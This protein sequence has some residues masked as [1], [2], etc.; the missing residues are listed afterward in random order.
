[1]ILAL[2]GHDPVL[3][4]GG[5]FIADNATVIGRV[6]LGDASSV[7]FNAVSRGDNDLIEVGR[8]SNVQDGAILHTDPGIPLAVGARVT[9]GHR[10][11]LHGCT[12]GDGTL[13]GIGSPVLNGAR[14]GARCLLGAHAL[15]TEGKEFPDGVLIIGAPARVA[16]DLT[17]EEIERIEA[18]AQIYVDN[19]RRFVAEAAAHRASWERPPG[20][21]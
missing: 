20:R 19:A 9:I 18:S 7:G 2:G 3:E 8:Q 1:M 12:F 13:I 16:R 14:I 10:A 21:E 15:V 11:M 5:H 6:R 17:A 4:G